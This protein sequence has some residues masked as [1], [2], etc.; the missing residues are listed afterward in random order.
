MA[1]VSPFR[2]VRYAP[3][4]TLRDVV[5]PPYDVLSAAQAAELAARSPYNAVH[6]DLPVPPG[7]E[8]DDAAYEAAA[9]SFRRWQAEGVLVRDDEPVVYLIDQTFRGPDGV[10]RTRRGF[11]ARLRL[12]DLGERVVLPHERTH[13]G[14]KMDRLRLYRA[15]HADLSPIFMLYPDDDGRVAAEVQRAADGADADA[16]RQ[17]DDGDGN[18]HRLTPLGGQP[19]RA[20]ASCCR[21]RRCTSPTA[22]IATRPHW[23]TATSAAPRATT[24]PTP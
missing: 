16:W 22:I 7:A 23:P 24:A 6:V 20:S 4:I 13:A 15:A 17:A 19:R 9:A 11:M 18:R 1:H 12:A 14:P 3:A 8:P 21:R 5:A 2:G 10:E